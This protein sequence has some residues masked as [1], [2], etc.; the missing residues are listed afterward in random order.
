M[1]LNSPYAFRSC[2]DL[3]N[4]R[5][6]ILITSLFLSACSSIVSPDLRRQHT[7]DLAIANGWHSQLISAPHFDLYTYFPDQFESNDNLWIYIEGDG[8]AWMT[9]TK[10]SSDPTPID[11]L[12]LRLALSQDHGNAAYLGR[13]C[14]YID[15]V[16]VN[17]NK[18]FWTEARF[19]PEVIEAENHAINM[20]KKQFGA[21][22]LTLVGYS[23]GAAV[24]LLLAARRTDVDRL[25]T[26]AGNL[27]HQ[28]WTTFHRINPL[29]GSL[30]PVNEISNLKHIQQWYFAGEKDTVIPSFLAVDFAARFPI[31]Q[32]PLVKILPEFDHRCCWVQSWPSLLDGIQ[33]K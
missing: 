7:A 25:I 16:K 21:K 24:A 5:F 32:R 12:V 27:D 26:I 22:R 4:F 17:C 2:Y 31:T 23:G 11:S 19:A 18:R 30:N 10:P 20:L 14:Q 9:P 33:E 8:F 1:I 6:F 13:P 29:S 3:Q 15:A 28:A